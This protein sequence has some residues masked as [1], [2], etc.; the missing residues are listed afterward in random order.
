M[1]KERGDLNKGGLFVDKFTVYTIKYYT[2]ILQYP[3][4]LFP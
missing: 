1:F 4:T 3:Y 2:I